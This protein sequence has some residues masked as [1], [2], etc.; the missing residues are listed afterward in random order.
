[1]LK[2]VET[3]AAPWTSPDSLVSR[4]TLAQEFGVTVK[5]ICR[6]EHRKLLGFD[7][8]VII[9]NRTYHRRRRVEAAK[10]LGLLLAPAEREAADPA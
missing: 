3:G 1:M 2:S 4:R 5:T 10:A 6:W 7:E 8:P 9:N